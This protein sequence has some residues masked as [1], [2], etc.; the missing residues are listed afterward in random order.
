MVFGPSGP[1]SLVRPFATRV[2][3]AASLATFLT[4]LVAFLASLFRIGAKL[5][6]FAGFYIYNKV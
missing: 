1:M 6:A 5:A 2:S 3:L 4:S